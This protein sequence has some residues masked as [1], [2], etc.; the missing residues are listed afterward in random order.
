MDDL[1]AYKEQENELLAAGVLPSIEAT[2]KGLLDSEASS[3][4]A[5]FACS[6][7]T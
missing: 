3:P 5:D 2:L 7:S 1:D 6:T 4:V